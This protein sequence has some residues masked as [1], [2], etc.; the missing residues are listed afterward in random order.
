MPAYSNSAFA[1]LPEVAIPA[2]PAYFFGSLPTGTQDTLGTVTN[3]ALTTNV[4]TV[5]ITISA[6]N[7]PVVGNFITVA[8]STNTSGL[9]N[10]NQAKITAISGTASTG[11]YTISYA[12]T[13]ANVT[14]VADTGMAYIP[15][16]ETSEALANSTSV[17]IYVPSNELRDLGQRNITVATTFPSLPTAATVTLYTAIANNP[18]AASPEWTSMGAV[19]VV[20]GGSVTTPANAS[21]NG[22]LVTFTTPSGRFFRVVIT[23]VSGGTSPTVVCKMIP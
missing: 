13:H 3:V 20:A 12:L 19:A 14:S 23:G 5:T 22:G 11:V 2:K 1:P 17:A 10:I 16:A 21:A 15:I 9:F 8:G 18:Q 7:I 4:A 6:G